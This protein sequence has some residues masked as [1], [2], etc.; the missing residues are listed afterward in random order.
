MCDDNVTKGKKL[1]DKKGYFAASGL[2]AV[3]A[4]LF[5]MSDIGIIPA[6]CMLVAGILF[7]VAGLAHNNR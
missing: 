6:L 7:L 3:S 5:W 1:K 2:M 4:V